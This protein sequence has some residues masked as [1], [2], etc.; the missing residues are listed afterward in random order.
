MGTHREVWTLE[1]I[2]TRL[3][4][5]L[6]SAGVR[7]AIVFGSQARGEADAWSDLD[8][9]LIA[10]THLPFIERFR[11]FPELF[12]VYPR[13]MELFVYTPEEFARMVEAENSFIEQ[14]LKDGVTIHEG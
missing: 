10:D 12:E 2:R 3:A 6:Q 13:A 7:R 14:V 4:P 1:E 8:L 11:A 5:H 9:V